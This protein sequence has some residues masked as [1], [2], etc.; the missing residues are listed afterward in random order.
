[1]YI[2]QAWKF[3]FVNMQATKA[4]DFFFLPL[5]SKSMQKIKEVYLDKPT[6]LN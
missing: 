5:S 1:M 2:V 3:K 4:M 6:T